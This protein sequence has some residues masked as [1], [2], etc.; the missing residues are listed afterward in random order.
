MIVKRIFR[1]CV[2]WQNELKTV[3]KLEAQDV[4]FKDRINMTLYD[5]QIKDDHLVII[6]ARAPSDLFGFYQNLRTQDANA[7]VSKILS[8]HMFSIVKMLVYLHS[9]NMSHNDIK[10]ENVVCKDVDG[11]QLAFIDFGECTEND[12]TCKFHVNKHEKKHMFDDSLVGTPMYCHPAI[13][14]KEPYNLFAHDLWSVGMSAMTL[15][16]NLSF[17][18]KKWQNNFLDGSWSSMKFF[19]EQEQK[20]PHWASFVQFANKM[21]QAPLQDR[22]LANK[23]L[24]QDVFLNIWK[25]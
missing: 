6:Y 22:P 23:L 3:L 19:T 17:P 25:E 10:P 2:T 12:P 8:W 15:M 20:N 24:L 18:G 11:K 7:D 4:D 9:M 5:Y 13:A 21:F 16:M 1:Q 14:R